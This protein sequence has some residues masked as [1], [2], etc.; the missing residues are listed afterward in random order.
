MFGAAVV[1]NGAGGKGAPG[2]AA[3]GGGAAGRPAQGGFGGV[4]LGG[5]GANQGEGDKT[6]TNK[7]RVEGSLFDEDDPAGSFQGIVGKD[8]ANN[9]K[10][11]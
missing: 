11:R 10:K 6:H 7:W 1:G 5:M 3:A 8:P 2:G 9:P 4:P